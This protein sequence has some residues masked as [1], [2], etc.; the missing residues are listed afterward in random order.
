MSYSIRGLELLSGQSNN[1]WQYDHQIFLYLHWITLYIKIGLN[2]Q[3]RKS[4]V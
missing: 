3:K 1:L 4:G 2:T